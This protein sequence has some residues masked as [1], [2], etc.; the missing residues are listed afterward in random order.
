MGLF[1]R[2]LD[3]EP[4]M[5]VEWV[6]ELFSGCLRVEIVNIALG[7]LQRL[8]RPGELGLQALVCDVQ[9]VPVQLRVHAEVL[10]VLR[11][12]CGER[13]W[14]PCLDGV[15]FACWSSWSSMSQILPCMPI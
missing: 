1:L 12:L 7:R 15:Y 14:E 6:V 5:G 8:S 2:V 10:S 11:Y 4:E 13:R 9:E 3:F